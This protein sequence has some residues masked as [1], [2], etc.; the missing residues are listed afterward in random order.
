MLR[1][2]P[3]DLH[4]DGTRTGALLCWRARPP[5][6]GPRGTADLHVQGQPDL[7]T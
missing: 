5:G 6:Q 2:A 7:P 1:D 3:T 4:G